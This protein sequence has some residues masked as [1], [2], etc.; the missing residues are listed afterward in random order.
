LLPNFFYSFK[1]A[2]LYIKR[3]GNLYANSWPN[4]LFEKHILVFIIM[5][6]KTMVTPSR[7]STSFY[8]Y[9]QCLK[10]FVIVFNNALYIKM[11]EIVVL[12]F[13]DV[14]SKN[15]IIASMHMVAIRFLILHSE[16]NSALQTAS[17]EKL[18]TR[19]VIK[20]CQQQGGTP[21]KTLKE[22]LRTGSMQ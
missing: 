3:N 11:Q 15:D 16:C 9:V 21:S 13:Y 17:T 8:C 10:L 5:N 12:L 4:F 7:R 14:I 18:E 1:R 19:A 6:L 20:F 2:I 22:Q